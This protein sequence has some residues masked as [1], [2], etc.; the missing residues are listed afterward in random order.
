[1][2]QLIHLLNPGADIVPAYGASKLAVRGLTHPP[3]VHGLNGD[4]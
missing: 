4:P 2:T 1:M 3:R